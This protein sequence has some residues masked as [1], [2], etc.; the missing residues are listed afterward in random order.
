M[1][2]I[3]A[4]NVLFVRVIIAAMTF[5]LK[6]LVPARVLHAVNFSVNAVFVFL[7]KLAVVVS[8]GFTLYIFFVT[9]LARR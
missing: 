5:A 4:L 9:Q 7:T 1:L 2:F 6:W 8:A 3:A